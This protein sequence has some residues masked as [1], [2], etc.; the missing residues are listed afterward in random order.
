MTEISA[1]RGRETTLHWRSN[2]VL[3]LL[4]VFLLVGEHVQWSDAKMVHKFELAATPRAHGGLPELQMTRSARFG[5]RR[6]QDRSLA[7]NL[8]LS[9]PELS[10][11]RL[12]RTPPTGPSIS[13]R[14]SRCPLFP[15]IWWLAKSPLQG[16]CFMADSRWKQ[17]RNI[18]C[19]RNVHH[20]MITSISYRSLKC[21]KPTFLRNAIQNT[22]QGS[23]AYHMSQKV[24]YDRSNPAP[25]LT[26]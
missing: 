8:G 14:S 7:P 3:K 9:F 10:S 20:S 18:K 15:I 23:N 26:A 12:A 25:E 19:L 21:Y 2:R 4:W 17:Y 22:G 5:A 1:P 6:S 11:S 16:M 24:D 13:A